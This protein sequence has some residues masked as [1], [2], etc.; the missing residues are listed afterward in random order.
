MDCATGWLGRTERREEMEGGDEDDV[1]EAGENCWGIARWSLMVE[2]EPGEARPSL[3]SE[4]AGVTG[5]VSMAGIGWSLK[6]ADS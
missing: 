3:R 1:L 2:E 4:G 5:G 6:Q